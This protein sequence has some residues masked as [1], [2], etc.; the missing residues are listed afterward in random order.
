MDAARTQPILLHRDLDNALSAGAIVPAS[1][2]ALRQA[3]PIAAAV[4]SMY[5]LCF[6]AHAIIPYQD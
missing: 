5:Q 6:G 2:M 4:A 3:S 1:L